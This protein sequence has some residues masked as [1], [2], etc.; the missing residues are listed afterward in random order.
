MSSLSILPAGSNTKWK[1]ALPWIGVL[2]QLAVCLPQALGAYSYRW[3]SWVVVSVLLVIPLVGA[4][5]TSAFPG[6]QSSEG[7][8]HVPLSGRPPRV[9]LKIDNLLGGF[10]SRCRGV[11]LRNSP[12]AKIGGLAT[13]Y[14]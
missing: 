7:G 4:S 10:K 8:L 5:P 3:G 9:V 11:F 6:E 1:G 14:R 13:S 2:V 12:E